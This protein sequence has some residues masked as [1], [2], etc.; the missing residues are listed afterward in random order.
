MIARKRLNRCDSKDMHSLIESSGY[1]SGFAKQSRRLQSSSS[2]NYD[3]RANPDEKCRFRARSSVACTSLSETANKPSVEECRSTQ[4]ITS[5]IMSNNM[6]RLKTAYRYLTP[7]I[8]DIISRATSYTHQEFK[9]LLI[10]RQPICSISYTQYIRAYQASEIINQVGEELGSVN[11]NLPCEVDFTVN[12]VATIKRED[13]LENIE[14][15]ADRIFID[16]D[17]MKQLVNLH[18]LITETIRKL[19]TSLEQ[20]SVE[21]LGQDTNTPDAAS[22]YQDNFEYNQGKIDKDAIRKH[23]AKHFIVIGEPKDKGCHC[24]DGP[25]SSTNIDIKHNSIVM[26]AQI[27]ESS[28]PLQQKQKHNYGSGGTLMNSVDS[29]KFTKKY[30]TR[31][32]DYLFDHHSEKFS[33]DEIHDLAK[34]SA[35]YTVGVRRYELKCNEGVTKACA[36]LPEEIQQEPLHNSE[37]HDPNHVQNYYDIDDDPLVLAESD[38]NQMVHYENIEPDIVAPHEH[39]HEHIESEEQIQEH[40]MAPMPSPARSPIASPYQSPRTTDAG[41]NFCNKTCSAKEESCSNVTPLLRE[42]MA[43]IAEQL[44][45][46]KE[47]QLIDFENKEFTPAE[48][49]AVEKEHYIMQ[50]VM[51]CLQALEDA[52]EKLISMNWLEV[53]S[54]MADTPLGCCYREYPHVHSKVAGIPIIVKISQT[55]LDLLNTGY[56][57]GPGKVIPEEIIQVADED[58]TIKPVTATRGCGCK[59]P[60]FKSLI[61]EKCALAKMISSRNRF[62]SRHNKEKDKVVM[63][64]VD[65]MINPMMDLFGMS[66]NS[67]LAEPPPAFQEYEPD[68]FQVMQVADSNT[69]L[70]YAVTRASLPNVTICPP[71]DIEISQFNMSVRNSIVDHPKP[72]IQREL[73]EIG[74][75]NLL[76]ASVPAKCCMP[77]VLNR[78]D[79]DDEPYHASL[80]SLPLT[81]SDLQLIVDVVQQDTIMAKHC[82]YHPINFTA[83]IQFSFERYTNF[84]ERLVP[85]CRVYLVYYF[86]IFKKDADSTEVMG[87][88]NDKHQ[89]GITSHHSHR[90]KQ[91]FEHRYSAPSTK[92]S[93]ERKSLVS[94]FFK[95]FMFS[96]QS[97]NNGED[98]RYTH[99]VK[100]NKSKPKSS[101][102]KKSEK[103]YKKIHTVPKRLKNQR[104][105]ACSAEFERF[106]SPSEEVK[107]IDD[108]NYTEMN[109]ISSSMKNFTVATI[110]PTKYKFKTR[111]ESEKDL[112]NCKRSSVSPL[113]QFKQKVAQSTLAESN[114]KETIAEFVLLTPQQSKN[115]E[116]E[117]K[118]EKMKTSKD[119]TTSTHNLETIYESEEKLISKEMLDSTTPQSTF[120]DFLRSSEIS[121]SFRRFIESDEAL[122]IFEKNQMEPEEFWSTYFK[123]RREL[124]RTPPK[125][126]SVTSAGDSEILVS[127]TEDD[128][129][130]IE[131][132]QEL[133]IKKPTK[134]QSRIPQ[135]IRTPQIVDT[136]SDFSID[137]IKIYESGNSKMQCACSHLS[138]MSNIQNSPSPN[139][140]NIYFSDVLNETA[141]K[142][143]AAEATS[144]HSLRVLA[145]KNGP[146]Y[147]TILHPACGCPEVS[148]FIPCY[149]DEK[150]PKRAGLTTKHMARM[151]ANTNGRHILL[152][153][154]CRI[155]R[156]RHE[157]PN[158]MNTNKLRRVPEKSRF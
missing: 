22:Y 137:K 98:A 89:R 86:E 112:Q 3:S 128:H 38:S 27:D 1:S 154:S 95:R 39:E 41:P 77:N 117:K 30:V 48:S 6:T 94:D 61:R 102:C 149:C 37:E 2:V 65:P 52:Q 118:S 17:L 130:T 28:Q 15:M 72:R 138:V 146:G 108:G 44:M 13:L 12:N 115:S 32:G 84:Q 127:H 64:T 139:K 113:N 35:P 10:K 93:Y 110:T 57:Y 123:M 111:K 20:V 97:Y 148:I 55:L 66:A 79:A 21:G 152:P 67:L 91:R 46:L 8:D 24:D 59:P 99:Q 100:V 26:D 7:I 70:P 76:R 9:E 120:F 49:P 157:T 68:I 69:S 145:N 107:R 87:N 23:I 19:K 14:R 50:E 25:V 63:M 101:K 105:Q 54:E 51:Y 92:S 109:K 31:T 103:D 126:C 18:E 131:P 56:P 80:N 40:I 45:I 135:R 151:A 141:A 147:I 156:L 81:T 143:P 158:K 53:N 155:P 82:N 75:H 90:R 74:M 43:K 71:M 140:T 104:L 29:Q 5:W 62:T 106:G 119:F 33:I 47:D 116:E 129:T 85:T 78:V 11:K 36:V 60:T 142:Q 73:Q 88:L 42:M 144:M 114:S 121:K 122:E 125:C 133:T 34:K 153:A 134:K 136:T 4:T 124:T 132:Q 16:R 150:G 58:T 83:T 96:T